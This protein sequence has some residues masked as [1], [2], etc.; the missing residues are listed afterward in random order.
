MSGV[1]SPLL[2]APSENVSSRYVHLNSFFFP[3]LGIVY[4]LWGVF[5]LFY[6]IRR[7]H[8]GYYGPTII[9][10]HLISFTSPSTTEPPSNAGLDPAAIAQIPTLLYKSAAAGDPAGG[11]ASIPVALEC[12]VCLG[13]F[14]DNQTLRVLPSCKHTFHMECID[15]WLASHST[16]PLCR[17]PLVF[18]SRLSNMDPKVQDVRIS[19]EALQRTGVSREIASSS[20]EFTFSMPNQPTSSTPPSLTSDRRGEHAQEFSLQNPTHTYHVHCD[21]FVQGFLYRQT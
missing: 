15:M 3:I 13:E 10:R 1:Q 4:L 14:Q 16:C 5:A 7:R 18:P 17:I 9:T 12:A 21:V 8:P 6:G 20:A 2:I 19:V 11:D